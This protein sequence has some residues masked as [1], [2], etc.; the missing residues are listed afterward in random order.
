MSS[1]LRAETFRFLRELARNNRKGWMDEHRD[2]YETAVVAPLR[3]LV[4]ALAPSVRALDSGF[5]TRP[6]FGTTLS[7]I[8]RDIRFAKDKTPYRTRLYVQF[9][10]PAGSGQLFLGVGSRELTAG[11]RSYGMKRDSVL[12][13]LGE[14][15]ARDNPGWL[16]RQARRLGRRYESYWYF[17]TG[18]RWTRCEGFP[19]RPGDWERLCG[20]VVRRRFTSRQAVSGRF[21]RDLERVFADLFPLYAFTSLAE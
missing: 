6:R 18:G 2:R 16:R 4:G 13:R 19:S 12:R 9:S 7:R 14:Q 8:N 1:G 15:R 5:D 10:G 11:F 3:E 17:T 21:T 20:L